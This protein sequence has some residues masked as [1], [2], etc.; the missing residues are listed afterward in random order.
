M[1]IRANVDARGLDQRVTFERRVISNVGGEKSGTWTAIGRQ[2]WA[3]VDGAKVSNPEPLLD[4]ALRGIADYTF[5][6]RADVYTRKALTVKDRI[7]WK[8]KLFNI[9][10]IPDQQLRGRWIGI[11]ARTGQNED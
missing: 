6:I 3:R 10:D 9:A 7:R 2:A 11:V 4:G 8:G 5:W 1:S